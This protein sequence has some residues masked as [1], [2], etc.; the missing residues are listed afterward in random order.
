MRTL[1]IVGLDYCGSTLVS[2]VLSSI[3]GVLNVGESHWIIDR[4]LGCRECH[5]K[6][7]PIFTENMLYDLRKCDFSKENWWD[8]IFRH[9]DAN[10]IVS[11]DKLPKHYDLFGVTDNILFLYKDPKSNIVSWC[12]RKF[13][14]S[15]KLNPQ[16]FSE[17]EVETGIRWWLEITK[18]IID[19]LEV[20]RAEIST[21]SLED[22]AEDPRGVTRALCGWLGM[23]FDPAAV[24]FWERDLHYIGGNHS[25]KRLSSDKHFYRRIVVDDRWKNH[26]S[27]ISMKRINE[28]KEISSLVRKIERISS[29]G[30]SNFFRLP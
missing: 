25:V 22:F 30:N 28:D 3:P 7:C 16:F 14:G 26:L 1:G 29:K 12:K 23:E 20:Q 2:N 13:H 4:N 15:D 10:L 9:T 18:K 21:L 8:I 17:T 24:D 27:D 6:P 19:W 11:T 5:S